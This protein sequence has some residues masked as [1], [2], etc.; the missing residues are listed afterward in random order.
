MGCE[1]ISTLNTAEKKQMKYQVRRTCYDGDTQWYEFVCVHEI[2][3]AY[4]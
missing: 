1:I 4:M 2:A 3:L